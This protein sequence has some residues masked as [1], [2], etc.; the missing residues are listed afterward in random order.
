MLPRTG[1]LAHASA[2]LTET[3]E[4]LAQAVTLDAGET[5]FEQGDPGAALYAVTHGSLEI[6]VLSEDGRKFALDVMRDG[7]VLGEIA[8]FDPGPRTATVTATEPTELL[9]IR[10]ADLLREIRTAPELGIDMIAL[11]GQRMRWMNRQ[12]TEQVFLPMQTRLARKVLYLTEKSDPVT[13]LLS[14][15][16]SELADFVGA[17]REA[18]SKALSEWKK[19][20]AVASSRRGIQI[21]D[22]AALQALADLDQ[23]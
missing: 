19:M 6:S 4:R 12:I 22:R 2:E 5:L 13:D 10:N 21:L 18:V 14:L 3:L 20:G 23:I 11:A 1:F 17:T 9:R 8:L 16:Q 15:S 7:A